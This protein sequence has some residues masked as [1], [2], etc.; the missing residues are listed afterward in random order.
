MVEI[1]YRSSSDRK[2][3]EFIT[4]GLVLFT[5]ALAQGAVEVVAIGG[6]VE[7]AGLRP[8]LLVWTL[9]S[10]AVIGI[11]L[12]LSP[13]IDKFDRRKL[14]STLAAVIAIMYGALAAYFAF[15][16]PSLNS[17]VLGALSVANT[18]TSSVLL[19]A[20]WALAR[21]CF[22]VKG[23][24]DHFGRLGSV[25]F[26]GTLVGTAG[27]AFIARFTTSIVPITAIL[28]VLFT[29]VAL[30]VASLPKKSLVQAQKGMSILPPPG[31]MG[32]SIRPPSRGNIDGAEESWA[33]VLRMIRDSQTLRSLATLGV[34]NGVV[35]TMMAYAVIRVLLE[36][37]AH[38]E[39]T[40]QY[41][42]LRFAEPLSHAIVQG[43]FTGWILRKAGLGRVFVATPAMLL[44]IMVLLWVAP[45]WGV[46][47]L[48]SCLLHAVFAVES[49]AIG[50]LLVVARPAVQGRLSLLV[51]GTFY[52][53]GYLVGIG[54]LIVLEELNAAEVLSEAAAK[55]GELTS[56]CLIALFGLFIASRVRTEHHMKAVRS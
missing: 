39:L 11:S 13:I 48:C 51:E 3:R 27:V 42:I 55:L 18:L 20:G 14:V 32:S 16:P 22:T 54:V 43:L 30:V 10:L 19:M 2:L 17:F 6:M 21:D 31:M 49:P 9:D 15:A 4:L 53:L 26:V 46:A 23:A 24:I 56:A 44:L 52:Q 33:Y 40:E 12:G 1:F 25:T 37:P 35:Y 50:A 5:A 34:V 36:S 41:G 29:I 7:S 8:V 28:F 45:V 47:L 38:D